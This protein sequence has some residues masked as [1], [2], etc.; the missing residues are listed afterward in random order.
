V[1][2][3]REI[4]AKDFL[5]DFHSAFTDGQLME[6][7]KVSAK[8]LE[9]IFKKLL[10]A[11]V[12]SASDLRSRSPLY[13]DTVILDLNSLE[14]TA[15]NNLSCLVPVY[16]QSNPACVGSVCEIANNGLIVSGFAAEPDQTRRLVI[17]SGDFFQI[18]SFGF[19]A[20]CRWFKADDP[21]ES[22]LTAFEITNI[23]D[24][25]SINLAALL[26]TVKIQET[27]EI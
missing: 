10:D 2:P 20:K 3:K 25:A 21:E 23:T 17:D 11:N 16:D 19:E 4:R 15:D 6:K 12:I 9:R 22:C 13:V 27:N 7:Y 18:D 26:R 1:K 5:I 24:S 8:G 14:F